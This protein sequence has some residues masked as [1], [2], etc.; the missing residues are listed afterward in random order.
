M[1][2]T[3]DEMKNKLKASFDEIMDR[4]DGNLGASQIEH[5]KSAAE[6]FKA[7]SMIAQTVAGI[8]ERSEIAGLKDQVKLLTEV[9]VGLA[10]TAAPKTPRKATPRAATPAIRPLRH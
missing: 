8:E 1:S 9:V 4:A 7:A 10:E 5:T 3:I 2:Q 6:L